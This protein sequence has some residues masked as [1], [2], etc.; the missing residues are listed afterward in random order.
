M[1][2][3]WPY[4]RAG[5]YL[6]SAQPRRI[7]RFTC[8]ACRRSFSSQ[9]FCTTYW[10]RRPDLDQRIFM[11]AIGGMALRQIARDIGCSPET[12]ARKIARLGR[13]C[14]LLHA[15]LMRNAPPASAV[16]VDGFE[17]FE[18]SQYFP[19]HQNLAVEPETD[20]F[21]YFND[22]ELRRKGRMTSAQKQRRDELERLFGRPDRQAV[23]KGVTELLKVA[24][25]D[26]M[27]A[28]IDSDDHPS[29]RPAIRSLDVDVEHRI[30]PGRDHRDG[31]NRL[32]SVNLLDLVIRHNSANHKRETIAWSKRRQASCERLAML[33]VWRNYMQ[34]RREKIRGSPTPA[35]A[36]GMLSRRLTVQEVLDSR[37][38]VSQM[39]LPGRWRQYY[40][41]T[42]E[43][44]AL[45]VQRRHVLRYAA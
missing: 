6:R 39:E 33:L 11:K 37:L 27:R 42:V 15:K 28:V 17:T 19:F 10:Q 43:T 31:R 2:P 14:M 22:S 35:M 4:K 12:V 18:W 32:W 13:H 36:R 7:Q 16:V 5:F 24:T 23:R 8:R 45:K 41:R 26:S 44:R 9:T 29:Y 34:G 38:F 40:E 1:C 21:I 30:T 3:D 25:T 20:F